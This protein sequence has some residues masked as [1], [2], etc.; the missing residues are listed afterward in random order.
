MSCEFRARPCW[1]DSRRASRFELPLDFERQP[2]SRRRR[3]L[4]ILDCLLAI[5]TR[6]CWRK[7]GYASCIRSARQPRTPSRWRDSHSAL[8]RRTLSTIARLPR[9]PGPKLDLGGGG[10]GGEQRFKIGPPVFA[11]PPSRLHQAAQDAVVFQAFLRPGALNHFA[12][13]DDRPQALLRQVV[14]RRHPRVP[15]KGAQVFFSLPIRRWRNVSARSWRSAWAQMRWRS[16]RLAA[17]FSCWAAAPNRRG[18]IWRT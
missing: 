11:L 1:C 7:F 2:A 3:P 17:F 4:S 15:Q 5:R 6:P 10:V 14:G 18:R 16:A 9:A 12:H 8:M 13:D